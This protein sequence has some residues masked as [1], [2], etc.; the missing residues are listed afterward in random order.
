MRLVMQE[1]GMHCTQ[2]VVDAL[3]QLDECCKA[4]HMGGTA[5]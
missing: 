4:R 3:D 2:Q 5:L 1:K